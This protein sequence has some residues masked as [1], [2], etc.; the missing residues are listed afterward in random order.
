MQRLNNTDIFLRPD[1]PGSRICQLCNGVI[2]E[3]SHVRIS[4][5]C[6]MAVSSDGIIAALTGE[7]GRLSPPNGGGQHH[8]W[9]ARVDENL[10]ARVLLSRRLPPGLLGHSVAVEAERIFVGGSFDRE[11]W[12]GELDLRVAA[13]K[14]PALVFEDLPLPT[15][16]KTSGKAVSDLL[17]LGRRLLAIDDVVS[18]S[19][20]LT[21]DLAREGQPAL[22]SSQEISAHQSDEHILHG[23]LGGGWL[24]LLCGSMGREGNFRH[25][26]LYHAGTVREVV[27]FHFEVEDGQSLSV[28]TTGYMVDSPRHRVRSMRSADQ[29][30]PVGFLPVQIVAVGSRFYLLGM[31]GEVLRLDLGRLSPTQVAASD[32]SERWISW[33]PT[34]GL[35]TGT[36]SQLVAVPVRDS[37]VVMNAQGEAVVIV[38]MVAP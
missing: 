13:K 1:G 14:A 23:A 15:L 27:S 12:L 24:A 21:F 20:L 16:Q 22:V 18:P 7:D 5:I 29:L 2:T 35:A 26:G 28:Q 3:G 36:A 8:L 9:I 31:R 33:E 19:R 25:L 10:K 34:R 4:P 37:V 38:G 30:F 32:G 17:L 11:A 6:P